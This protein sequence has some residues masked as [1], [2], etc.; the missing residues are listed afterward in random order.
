MT[1]EKEIEQL[2]KEI[3][4]IK[5]HNPYSDELSFLYYQ[6]HVLEKDLKET[7]NDK[8]KFNEIK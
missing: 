4:I 8:G 7:E 1:K 3:E 5:Q 2:K 6:L